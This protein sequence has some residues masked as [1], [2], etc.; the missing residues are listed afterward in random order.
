[1]TKYREILRLSGLGL[2]QQNIADSCN[3]FEKTVNRVFKRAR[4]LD[5]SW[6]L[7]ENDTDAVLA[8]KFFPS[9]NQVASNK[10][11]P[12]YDYIRKELLRNGVSK[13]LLWTEY[14]E[15]CRAN[16]DEPL[17]YSQ[18]CY[19]SQQDEQKRRATMHISR[20][21]GEQ[22]EVDWAGNPATI[23]DP[24]T[25]EILKAYIFVA[26]M[27]Y[28]QYAYVEAFQLWQATLDELY[29][30]PGFLEMDR[31]TLIAELIGPQFQ[32]KVSTTLKNRLTA[33]HLKCSPEELS[34]CVDSDKREYLPAGI[35]EVFSSFDFIERGYSLCNLGE[36]DAGKSYLAKAIGIKA[37]NR[38]NVGCFHSEELLESMVALKEQDYDKYAR[39]MKKYL[40][41]E[42][43]IL[44]DFL[45]HTITDER[46]IKILFK[47]LEKRN[48]QRKS[49]IIC[50]Q[51][52]SNNWKTMILN[53]EASAN[54][55]MK[56]ATKHYTIK[57]NTR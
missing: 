28:S 47:L 26:V 45:L 31:L 10:G 20:K 3:V 7:D 34:D 11:M 23:I 38:Y 40:K 4:E 21:P 1:M 49:T 53:D 39:K 25:N 30:N 9:A 41:W 16:G 24:D 13:K 55:I 48:E 43:I 22:A 14:M 27:T 8:E 56:R 33:A 35:T 5:I 12:D 18:F 2:S 17:M 54:F 46:E 50:S 19:H 57:I 36:S 51:R 15:D 29:H 37:C 52:D 6:S 44:D 42:L 32:E